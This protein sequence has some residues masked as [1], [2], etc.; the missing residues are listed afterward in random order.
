[1]SV[2]TKV[3]TGYRRFPGRFWALV[4]TSFIDNIGG[5][6]L[7]P[8]L[9]L[10]ITDKFGVG[11]TLAGVI[12]GLFSL[13]GLLGSTIGG[14]LTDRFGRK[15]IILAGLIFSALSTVSLAFVNNFSV[16]YPL[17]ALIG[18]LGGISGPAHSAMVADMLPEEKRNEGF[19]ILRV[20]GNL[21]WIIGPTIGGFIASQSY[22]Y[23]FLLDVL[24]SICTAVMVFF[25]IP[26]TMPEKK[27]GEPT[28]SILKTLAG[29][30]IVISDWFFVAF[31]VVS[32]LM[33]VVYQQMYSTLSV[34]MRDVHQFPTNYYGGILSASAV[35][36]V[37]TQ[38][39]ISQQTQK[40]PPMLMMALG[41]GL[42]AIGFGMI[43][44]IQPFY[45]FV[46]SV[47][48]ITLGEMISVPV[49]Q[50]LAASFA[51]EDM[52]GRYMAVSSVS[53]SLPSAIGPA[54]AGII[55]DR[56]DPNWVWYL[57]G[58]LC[59]VAVLGFFLLHQKARNEPRFQN[60]VLAGED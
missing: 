35:L 14:A 39:W 22:L 60:I 9:A 16:L 49:S 27:Q 23:L 37:L 24:F 50:A 21:S 33:L 8:F 18:I 34:Y 40:K 52:R 59:S 20:A 47:L 44:F 10:Y 17:A 19:G 32:M 12:L 11:M 7:W 55:L 58:I 56:Y 15:K 28:E 6:L 26:E 25:I 1:M 38:F 54:V 42:Y 29:Y 30:R 46:V 5:T 57:G 53:W 48:V 3:Q 4:F 43:G 41:C 13:F 31:L 36:V 45:L 51:P 2:F